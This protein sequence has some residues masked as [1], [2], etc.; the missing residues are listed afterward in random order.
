MNWKDKRLVIIFLIIFTNLLGFGIIIPLLPYYVESMGAGVV[1]VGLL[2]SVYSLFQ[3]VS[4]PI[5]GVLSDKYGR[6]PILVFSI[7]GTAISFFMMGLAQTISVLFLARILDGL[8]GGNISTAQ[9]Y[10]ADITTKKNRAE[11]MGIIMAAFSLGLILGPAIGGLLSIHG[12]ATPFFVAGAIALL[13]SILTITFLPESRKANSKPKKTKIFD[14]KE[15]KTLVKY[16]NISVLLLSSFLTMFSF[17]LMQAV[18]ALFTEHNLGFDAKTNGL[19]FT[20]LG[21]LGVIIQ[22]FLLKR[23]VK[24]LMN[25]Q[26]IL[27]SSLGM[28]LAF[29]LMGIS[30]N[31]ILLIISLT[32]LALSRGIFRPVLLGELSNSVSSEKQGNI[33]GLNQSISSLA[34]LIGPLFG[35]ILYK[36]LGPRSPFL[37][38]AILILSV[39]YIYI[40][41]FKEEQ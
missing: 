2:A 34:R 10:I 32:V 5:L 26:I 21:F 20:Y 31:L 25:K 35:A 12:Y 29:F 17:A 37:V 13:A 8:S 41:S 4:S 22:L 38:S 19:L 6:R 16:P 28:S 24:R 14:L 27:I 33:A 23:I 18:F 9:A 36:I 7:L 11:G 3:L 30:Y 40:S 1:T 39:S 15:I